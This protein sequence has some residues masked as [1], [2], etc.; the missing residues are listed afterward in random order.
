MKENKHRFYLFSVNHDD[1]QKLLLV[2]EHND[3]ETN[4][5]ICEEITATVLSTVTSQLDMM[6]NA[7][8]RFR[9][10]KTESRF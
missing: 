4:C 5:L 8:T 3:Y 10:I 1:N 2:S 7:R 9:S 6:E